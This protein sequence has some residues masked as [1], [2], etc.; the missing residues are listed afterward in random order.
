MATRGADGMNGSVPNAALLQLQGEILE[1]VAHGVALPAIA[2]HVCMVAEEL[3]GDVLCSILTVDSEGRLHPLAAPSLPSA[4]TSAT[5]N[6]PAGPLSGSCGASAWTGEAVESIDIATDSH[7]Q[8]FVSIALGFGLRACW[9]SPIKAI[10][11]RVLGTFAFYYREPRGPTALERDIVE[12]CVHVCAIALAHDEAQARI[13]QLAYYDALTGL[14]NRIQFQQIA[15]Q[16]IVGL[17]RGANIVLHSIDLDDFKA[18]NDAFGHRAGDQLLVE[19]ARRLIAIAH[20]TGTRVARLGGDEFALVQVSQD[21]TERNIAERLV[22]V[23]EQ[24]FELEDA[25]VDIGASIGVA[26]GEAGMSLEELSRRADLALYAAKRDGGRK[27]HHFSPDMDEHGRLRT[28]LKQDLRRALDDGDFRLVYQPIVDLANNELIAVEA[29]L[30]WNHPEQGEVSPEVFIPI[31]EEA[32]LIGVIGD[33][34]LR[35][36]TQAAAAWPRPIKLGVNLSPLQLRRPGLVR[37]VID[38]LQE[39]GLPPHRLDLEVTESALLARDSA[40]RQALRHLHDHGVHLSLDDFG[41][42]YSSL[43]LL[44]MFPFDR[45]K[46]DM[47]FVRDIGINAGSMAIIDSVIRLAGELGMRSTAEGVETARQCAWLLAHSCTEGQ[48]HWFSE[49]LDEAALRDLLARQPS[50]EPLLL[51]VG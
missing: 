12:H 38:V 31:A 11:G 10:D 5:E 21:A 41:T 42:G 16:A 36:A 13:F 37:K 35:E 48:G 15:E 43:Q 24:P 30:R 3:A 7:W 40:T 4:F 50:A 19:V 29:L 46:I 27:Y 34:V 26:H 32:G 23:I 1:D 20:D 18:V 45:I 14:P 44:R 9:S 2:D 17:P 6:L 25:C 39:T 33:W 51:P 8:P 22:E 49:A 28:S 47:S